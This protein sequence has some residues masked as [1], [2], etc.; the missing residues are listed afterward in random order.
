MTKRI[1]VTL[2]DEV[3]ASLEHLPNVSAYVTEAIVRRQRASR[4]RAEFA[5]RGIPITDDGLARMRE[6]VQAKYAAQAARRATRT[7]G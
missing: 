7:A 3:A 1:T 2:P 4:L 5:A 6:R